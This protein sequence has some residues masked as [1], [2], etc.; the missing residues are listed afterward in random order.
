MPMLAEVASSGLVSGLYATRD[1]SAA[2]S[3]GRAGYQPTSNDPAQGRTAAIGPASG[4][5][6]VRPA[7]V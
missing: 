4:T 6:R 7:R 1:V 5:A 2:A 3:R